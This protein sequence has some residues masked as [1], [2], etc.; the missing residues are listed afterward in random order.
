MGMSFV[1]SFFIVASLTG[2]HPVNANDQNPL[3]AVGEGPSINCEL[4]YDCRVGR[5]S[6]K[7]MG[8]FTDKMVDTLPIFENDSTIY[9][10]YCDCQESK[11]Q[12]GHEGMTDP[13]C[14]TI[15]RRCPDDYGQ[16]N[17]I[18]FN[19][20]PCVIDPWELDKYFMC[21]CSKINNKYFTFD[22]DYC[23]TKTAIA[24][25]CPAPTGYDPEDFYC[26]NGGACNGKSYDY[27]DCPAN[28]N[29]PR[30]ELPVQYDKKCD[31]QCTNGGEC[32][33]GDPK[34][35]Q[36][37]ELGIDEQRSVSNMHCKCPDGFFGLLCSV[38]LR[39]CGTS[40]HYCLNEGTCVK[41]GDEYTCDCTLDAHTLHA[42]ENCQHIATSYCEGPY[43]SFC[44]NNGKCKDV[45][46]DEPDSHPGC[47]CSNGFYGE[48]CEHGKKA[49]KTFV[50]VYMV[51]LLFTL[52]I[53]AVLFNHRNKKKESEYYGA[54][55]DAVPDGRMH[56]VDI[57]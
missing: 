44:T 30:C 20:A 27:C 12:P 22:G 17:F 26:A 41:E 16:D 31:L 28:Y 8:V 14:R 43:N 34:S 42:G 48:Y 9:G 7:S 15:F 21:D 39:V 50:W 38:D 52:F 23:E 53:T 55:D 57:S 40:G 3:C 10:Q 37:K 54:P 51:V 33:I 18:C 5:K 46:K 49:A 32:V 19:D 24:Q 25:K 35:N 47:F 45:N 13:A 6:Y 4:G 36:Y 1:T 11:V 56:T 2:L 29:G